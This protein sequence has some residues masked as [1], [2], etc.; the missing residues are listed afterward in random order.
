MLLHI[1]PGKSTPRAH[2]LENNLSKASSLL[3]ENGI[4]FISV[5]DADNF[6]RVFRE[7]FLEFSLEHINFFTRNSLQNLMSRY[8]LKNIEFNSISLNSYG[9]YALNSL[10][11]KISLKML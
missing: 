3:K 9:G 7:P 8:D 5:P 6:G 2:L 1:S 4:M 11:K 10:W